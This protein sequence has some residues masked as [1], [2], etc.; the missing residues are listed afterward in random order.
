MAPLLGEILETAGH[1]PFHFRAADEHRVGALSSAVPWR[2]HALLSSTCRKVI[3]WAQ[4]EEMTVGKMNNMLAAADA[5]VLVTWLPDPPR[6]ATAELAFQGFEPTLRNMEHI[7]AASA[8]V[9]N[10]LLL[11]TD[12]GFSSYWSS[13][14]M[15]RSE[16][17]YDLLGLDRKE[18]LLGA[19]FLFP[20]EIGDADA[21]PGKWRDERGALDTWCRTVE[22]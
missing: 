8:A 4:R 15:L 22:L 7:A 21:K 11:A 5:C 6:D 14:G 10:L 12:R 13:G 18:V 20:A 19:I 16:P 17:A 9:Q 1:A 3:D 2:C